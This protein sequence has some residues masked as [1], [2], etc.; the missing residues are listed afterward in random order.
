MKKVKPFIR[1]ISFSAVLSVLLYVLTYLAKPTVSPFQYNIEHVQ[2]YYSLEPNTVDMVYVGGSACF[3]YYQPLKAWND[4]GIVSFNYATGGV[5][6]ESYKTMIKEVLKT[7]SPKLI[8]V[9]ARPLQYRDEGSEDSNPPSEAS[10][11]GVLT[12][13]RFST[14][15]MQFVNDNL[16]YINDETTS[17]Y[18]D[19]IK[20]HDNIIDFHENNI[21]MLFGR[22]FDK[23]NGYYFYHNHE[24]LAKPSFATNQKQA[25]SEETI[26]IFTDLLDYMKGT[27]AD[28][29]FVV[30]PYAEKE[31]HK[32]IYNFVQDKIND[33]GYQFVDFNDYADEMQIDYAKDF[34]DINHVNIFGSEK[35]TD[36]LNQYIVNR[37]SVPNRKADTKYSFMNNYLS[38]W[39]AQVRENK[40]EISEK[41]EEHDG[42]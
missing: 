23:F 31:E 1:I 6:L 25:V 37:Y 42:Q 15:K 19:L 17:Y 35:Y 41:I 40:A 20:Y 12:G 2:G 32:K 21:K 3:V 29:L 16:H 26:N 8:V 7:Q 33:Y 27:Q 24:A 38:E 18:F 4:H 14:N 39:N 22:Y 5:D 11:R 30:S 34:C 36:F 13:M 9:D 10:Y 28:Y